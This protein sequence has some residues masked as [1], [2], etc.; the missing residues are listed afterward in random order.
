M[1]LIENDMFLL[2]CLQTT[3]HPVAYVNSILKT[4]IWK[5]KNGLFLKALFPLYWSSKFG[6]DFISGAS[7]LPS[8]GSAEST[9]WLTFMLIT[10]LNRKTYFR[11]PIFKG[12]RLKSSIYL[13]FTATWLSKC[14]FGTFC[15]DFKASFRYFW[16]LEVTLFSGNFII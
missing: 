1:C 2:F 10:T 8:S 12:I 4:S 9:V 16:S 7:S 15:L 3:L 11:T 6:L 14:D 13:L 5:F